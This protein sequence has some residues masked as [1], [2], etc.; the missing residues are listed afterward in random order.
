[1]VLLFMTVVGLV[2]VA[3]LQL[4]STSLAAINVATH[5][6]ERVSAVNAGIDVVIRDIEADTDG[7]CSGATL[8]VNS[9][10]VSASCLQTPP[11]T[12]TPP[13][14]PDPNPEIDEAEDGTVTT[15]TV[16][17]FVHYRTIHSATTD[18]SVK[19]IEA[20][21]FVRYLVTKTTQVIQPPTPPAPEPPSDPP[22]PDPTPPPPI[23]PEPTFTT[24][25]T[26]VSWAIS[27][28]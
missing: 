16:E 27:N 24:D 14:P 12:P 26:I 17:Y 10:N 2:T 20:T 11:P 28:R 3:L 19:K 1:M 8:E 23:H 7:S 6:E 13:P 21:A 22:E 9:V 15:T 18:S 25:L 5:I 4:T